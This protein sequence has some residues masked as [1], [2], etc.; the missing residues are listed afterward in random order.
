MPMKANCLQKGER[1]QVELESEQIKIR[2][3]RYDEN[4]GWYTAGSLSLPLNQLALLEQALE[5][6]KN[7]RTERSP[8]VVLPFPTA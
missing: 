3:E 6:A 2:S 5:L 1:V 7:R 4:L 8:A